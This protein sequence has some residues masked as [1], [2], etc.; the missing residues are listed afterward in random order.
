MGVCDGVPH[1]RS[2]LGADLDQLVAQRVQGPMFDLLRQ[3]QYPF[4]I[5]C[6]EYRRSKRRRATVRE[7][8]EGPFGDQELIPS[9]RK[10]LWSEAGDLD[11][12]PTLVRR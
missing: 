5:V 6:H 3:C 2:D 1:S 12:Y 8:K 11:G 9:D 10:L 7:M 4:R